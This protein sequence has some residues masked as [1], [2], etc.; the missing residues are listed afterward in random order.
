MF[1][2]N[3]GSN[4][5]DEQKFCPYCG[6]VINAAS[7]GSRLRKTFAD[8]NAQPVADNERDYQY[9]RTPVVA[10]NE[11]AYPN[12]AAPSVAGYVN[13]YLGATAPFSVSDYRDAGRNDA[14]DELQRAYQWFSKKQ[15]EYDEYDSI[16]NRLPR[17]NRVGKRALLIWGCIIASVS[18][19]MTFVLISQKD[20]SFPV[21]LIGILIGAAMILGF[22]LIEANRKKTVAQLNNRLEQLGQELTEHFIAFGKCSFGAE[23]SNPQIISRILNLVRSGRADSVKEGI[24]IMLSDLRMD[25]MTELSRITAENAQIMARNTAAAARGAKAAAVFSAANFFFK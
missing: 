5:T 10:Q 25:Q 22:F 24:N 8:R 3:C 2:S 14:L 20:E 15:R 7:N 4:V 9:G 23:Y 19:M 11:P 13:T 16:S 6:T 1:C 12:N 17:M 21:G 18:L